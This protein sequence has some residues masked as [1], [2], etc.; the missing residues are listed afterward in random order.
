MTKRKAA[1]PRRRSADP[2]LKTAMP[3][4]RDPYERETKFAPLDLKQVAADGSFS[5]YASIFGKADLGGDL[6]E[7]GAFAKSLAAR[8]ATGVKMLFQH[9]PAEPI[10]VWEALT[11]DSTG[12]F[13]RGRLMPEVARA[14][15]VLSL[16][17][18]GALDGL[19]IGFRT[20]KG[21]ADPKTGIRRLFEIDLWEISVVTFPMLPE[22]RVETVK[23]SPWHM[24]CEADVVA[25]IRRA[26]ELVRR[27]G[28]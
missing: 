18:A 8:G 12:L 20:V 7:P 21:R 4:A 15:E 16:M 22:A 3:Q 5:G 1:H 28:V 25:A 2:R 17:R 10:G 9:D 19:S 14:R 6:V 27:I 13:A 11:E 26:T 23:R 24:P